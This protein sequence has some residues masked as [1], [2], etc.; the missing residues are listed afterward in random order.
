MCGTA[1]WLSG[2]GAWCMLAGASF[3]QATDAAQKPQQ[4]RPARE[5]RPA[6]TL[7]SVLDTVAAQARIR[8]V[9]DESLGPVRVTVPDGLPPDKALLHVLAPYDVFY[10]H[11]GPDR[12][13]ATLSAIWV[14]PRG[15]ASD[16]APVPSSLWGSTK[17]LKAQLSDDDAG[18]R[19]RAYE[20]LIERQADNGWPTLERALT[21]PEEDVRTSA[22]AAALEVGVD[23]PTSEVLRLLADDPSAHVRRLALEAA[24]LREDAEAV[25]SAAALDADPAVR[26]LSAR[27]LGRYRPAPPDAR[28]DDIQRLVNPAAGTPEKRKPGGR[29]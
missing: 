18:V 4:E 1:R 19:S 5:V 11:T 8:I 6:P 2:L 16:L 15:A 10:L 29:H 26:D 23:V 3:A 27:I 12:K 24:E 13:T 17:E 14:Y 21:D 20:T 7:Q 22:L 25:A 28:S 9:I